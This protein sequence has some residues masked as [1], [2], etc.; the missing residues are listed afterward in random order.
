M[1]VGVASIVGTIMSIKVHAQ[2]TVDD[3]ASCESS[4]CVDAVNVIRE[5]LKNFMRQQ[6]STV[7]ASSLCTYKVRLFYEQF[8]LPTL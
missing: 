7:D 2:S 3:S 6:S 5:D 8:V 4:T 1:A